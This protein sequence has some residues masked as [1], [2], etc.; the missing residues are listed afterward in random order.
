[1]RY[2][3]ETDPKREVLV[4]L[5]QD[6][7]EVVIEVGRWVIARLNSNGTLRLVSGI[8]EDNEEGLQVGDASEILLD[9]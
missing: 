5:R 2:V 8:P 7:D 9:Y 3:V 4:K 1:M 6:G